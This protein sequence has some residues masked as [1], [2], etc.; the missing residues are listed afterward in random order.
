MFINNFYLKVKNSQLDR[1][2]RHIFSR[3]LPFLTSVGE[4]APNPVEI[5][6]SR[7][8]GHQA[9][10]NPLRVKGEEDGVKNF[11]KVCLEGGSTFEI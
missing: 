6:Y 3:G 2:P 8:G 11:G 7:E 10:E 5:S 1:G 9:W 4:N